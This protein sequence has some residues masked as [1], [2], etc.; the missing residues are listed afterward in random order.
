MLS[1]GSCDHFFS[2]CY[3][4]LKDSI[5]GYCKYFYVIFLTSQLNYLGN[6]DCY[7]GEYCV[8]LWIIIF[9]FWCGEGGRGQ[10]FFLFLFCCMLF[11]I[12]FNLWQE[13]D[14][15]NGFGDDKRA[16]L[17]MMNF[18]VNEVAFAIDKLG[19]YKFVK[20]PFLKGIN[21]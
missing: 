14:V 21:L 5:R 18:S 9:P 11:G 12:I 20:S 7:P 2:L 10:C 3:V 1:S 17:L 6:L 16:S 8:W 19:R 15:H 13:P 4:I